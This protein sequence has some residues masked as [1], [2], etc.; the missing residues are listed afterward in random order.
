[1]KK[2]DFVI[3]F[4]IVICAAFL[5]FYNLSDRLS[6]DWDQENFAWQAKEMIVDHKFTLIGTNTSIGGMYLGPFYT[7][8]S[9]FFYFLFQMNPIGGGVLSIIFGLLTII[10]LYIVNLSLFNRGVAI[11]SSILYAFSFSI[12]LW[13]LVAWNPAPFYLYSVMFLYFLVKSLKNIKIL[14]VL[15]FLLGLG[16]HIHLSA[17]TFFPFVIL[18]IL[19]NKKDRL[20]YIF[21]S[22]LTFILSVSPLIIFDLRHNFHN[23][24]QVI[25]FL[26]QQSSSL[27]GNGF[28]FIRVAEI[29]SNGSFAF[30]ISELPSR[31]KD[32]LLPLLWLSIATIYMISSKKVREVI[33][34]IFL[35]GIFNYLFFSV[36]PGLVVEY[37]L[38]VFVP[39][40]LI[41]FSV[42]VQRI[43]SIHPISQIFCLLFI[44]LL[45]YFNFNSWFNYNKSLSLRDK[46]EAVQFIVD[47]ANDEPF[48][49]SLTTALGYD[50]GYRYLLWYHKAKISTEIKDKVYTI[51][52]PVGVYNIKPLKV[53]NG[54]GILWEDGQK[55]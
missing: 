36:Y 47:D 41:V 10:A 48:R 29:I 42:F 16:L 4:I 19:T 38:M 22:L 31:V 17:I 55:I 46:D 51:V 40:T 20:K 6:F 50:T 8:L 37:Y 5:R 13:D 45:V 24:N 23:T 35:I 39:L 14:L 7:Y 26:F 28:Q 27:Q 15:S 49:I 32:F 30:L 9:N 12:I 52:A 3:L 33:N 54:V 34:I 2:K 53:F 43:Y 18:P 21:F 11:I 44:S 25:G 1:M